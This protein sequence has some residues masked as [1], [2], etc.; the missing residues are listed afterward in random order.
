MPDGDFDVEI[1]SN[2]EMNGNDISGVLAMEANEFIKAGGT[3][4]QILM[5]NGSVSTKI[6]NN[7]QLTNGA[8]YIT[9]DTNTQLTEAQVDA[10]VANNGYMSVGADT[11]WTN[12]TMSNVS[13]GVLEYKKKHGRLIVKGQVTPSSTNSSLIIATLPVG[14]RPDYNRFKVSVKNPTGTPS[15]VSCWVSAGGEVRL[16]AISGS[17]YSIDLDFTLDTSN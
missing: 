11:N 1:D 7:N 4:S 6:T 12:A 13:S 3:A 2:L 9:T 17:I 10:Y 14:F 5:A 15:V 16:D 8:G